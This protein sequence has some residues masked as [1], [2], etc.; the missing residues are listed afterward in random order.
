MIYSCENGF[1]SEMIAYVSKTFYV[2]PENR[3]VQLTAEEMRERR[4][5]Q[6]L[7]RQKKEAQSE[8]QIPL[9]IPSQLEI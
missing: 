5:R 6:L 8:A 2:S 7:M 4:T 9:L 3:R 1:N